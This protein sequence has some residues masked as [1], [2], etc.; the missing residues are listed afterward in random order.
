MNFFKKI[1]INFFTK[2]QTQKKL[3]KPKQK[4][5]KSGQ[6]EKPRN[7]NEIRTN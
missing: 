1:Q 6:E 5:D 2:K 4:L 7:P 3:S